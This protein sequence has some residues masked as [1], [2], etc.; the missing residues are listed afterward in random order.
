MDENSQA[1]TQ[2]NE[3]IPPTQIAPAALGPRMISISSGEKV[4]ILNNLSI[5]RDL[6][7]DSERS[8][9][10]QRISRT[11][12]IFVFEGKSIFF[13]DLSSNGT[14]LLREGCSSDIRK[15]ERRRLKNGDVLSFGSSSRDEEKYNGL[16]YKIAGLPQ[17]LDEDISC[18]KCEALFLFSEGEQQFYLEKGF[19]K[20]RTCKACR[21]QRWGPKSKPSK[22]SGHGAKHKARGS[23]NKA[24]R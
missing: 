24:R 15:L 4:D 1:L 13:Q 20:P 8:D 19:T 23:G 3:L 12:G 7:S 11:H 9:T 5:G 14:S 17:S 10:E 22:S 16:A 21:E 6:I 2:Q 18:I